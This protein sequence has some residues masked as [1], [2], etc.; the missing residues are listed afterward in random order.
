MA[1]RSLGVTS[2]RGRLEYLVDQAL[3]TAPGGGWD[4]ISQRCRA[5]LMLGLYVL[6]YETGLGREGDVR[7][8]LLSGGACACSSPFLLNGRFLT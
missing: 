1:K 6:Q 3:A 4:V 8:G 7:R 2:L 5:R